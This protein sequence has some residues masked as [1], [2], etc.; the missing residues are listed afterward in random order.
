MIK[1]WNENETWKTA[2]IQTLSQPLDFPS[3]K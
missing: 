2:D 1:V 3:A